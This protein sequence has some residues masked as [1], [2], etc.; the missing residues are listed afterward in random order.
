M[1]P[2]E[3][4]RD[5]HVVTHPGHHPRVVTVSGKVRVFCSECLSYPAGSPREV[6]GA[7]K[8]MT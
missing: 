2:H 4:I 6:A 8:P 5:G 3:H 1:T 7:P